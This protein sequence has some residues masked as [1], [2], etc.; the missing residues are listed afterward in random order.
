M[1]E[2]GAVGARACSVSAVAVLTAAAVVY[3]GLRGREARLRREAVSERLMAGCTS[4]DNAALRE[5]LEGFRRR[6]DEELSGSVGGVS[7]PRGPSP[8]SAPSFS[9]PVGSSSEGGSQ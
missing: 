7:V 9:S 8:V 1:L 4:R 6:L 2:V 3:A 5:Q